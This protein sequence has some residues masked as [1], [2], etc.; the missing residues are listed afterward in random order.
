MED[1]EVNVNGEQYL[2]EDSKTAE[3]E[4][5]MEDWDALTDGDDA[6]AWDTLKQLMSLSSYDAPDS[7]FYIGTQEHLDYLK[8]SYEF[9]EKILKLF[10][11]TKALGY[12][13]IKLY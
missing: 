4:L 2:I 9:P 6:I 1:T 8:S 11:M 3:V 12:E 13:Y 5:S 10:I 7:I